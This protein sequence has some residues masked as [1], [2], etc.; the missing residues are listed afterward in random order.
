MK[1]FE[2]CVVLNIG[3]APRALAKQPAVES[4]QI[5][6][7]NLYIYDSDGIW[8]SL[9][10]G[11]ETRLQMGLIS[12][13]TRRMSNDFAYILNILHWASSFGKAFNS[14][15][16]I[17]SHTAFELAHTRT[18]RSE[19]KINSNIAAIRVRVFPVPFGKIIVS[20]YFYES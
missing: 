6:T 11:V 15:V 10:F 20:M 8:N 18:L 14:R 9:P 17:S 7:W 5:T 2:K 19:V 16:V 3:S 12:S 4:V 1:I 13:F